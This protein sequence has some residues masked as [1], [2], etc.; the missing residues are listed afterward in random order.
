MGE[1]MKN[2]ILMTALLVTVSTT[3]QAKVDIC[4]FDLQ[5]KAGES[6]KLTE[7]WALAAKAWGADLNLIPYR[8]EEKAQQNFE[9]KKCDGVSMTSM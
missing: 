7:E 9:A 2:G 1:S 4:V 6:Y 5:G 8:D 3:A